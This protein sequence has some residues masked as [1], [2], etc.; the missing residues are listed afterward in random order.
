MRKV[1]FLIIVVFQILL[2]WNLIINDPILRRDDFDL[3]TPLKNINSLE[4]YFQLVET[5]KV[6][7]L[8]PIRDMTLLLNVKLEQYT[9]FGFYHLTNLIIWLA[10]LFA[11]WRLLERLVNTNAKYFWLILVSIHPS[12][13]TSVFWISGRKH[14]LSALFILI[15]TNLTLKNEN[16]YN[17]SIRNSSGI[18]GSYILSIFSQP[19]NLLWPLWFY[20]K[21][22]KS[23]I[24]IALLIVMFVCGYLNY[25]YYT[26]AFTDSV[27]DINKFNDVTILQSL[28]VSFLGLSRSFFQVFVPFKLAANYPVHSVFNLLGII[29]ILISIFFVLKK[30][31]WELMSW[32][33]FALLPL[34]VIYTK[35]TRIFVS[36]TYLI[37][38]AFGLIVIVAKSLEITLAKY[39]QKF[40]NA[41]AFFIILIFSVISFNW[42]QAWSSDEALWEYSYQSDPSPESAMIYCQILQSRGLFEEAFE[43]AVELRESNPERKEVPLLISQTISRN[44]KLSSNAKLELFKK[45]QTDDPWY[46][47]YYSTMLAQSGKWE[48]AFKQSSI[49]LLKPWVFEGDL[50]VVTAENHFFCVQA[51]VDNCNEKSEALI[52][53]FKGVPFSHEAYSLRLKALLNK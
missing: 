13:L 20:F 53:S 10:V 2:S 46:L 6:L 51:Q 12:L 8:Q 22:R 18:I 11:F 19:I 26:G 37:V 5:N 25:K 32:F 41:G 31:S 48:E 34:I 27:K 29:F 42:A 23:L 7:D 47:Y 1:V 45:Y 44:P 17:K 39:E 30:R 28:S 43:L 24:N 15:A 52:N 36:D 33:L 14:L 4:N 49:S 21:N 9:G 3:I 50:P 40:L 38:T 16:E 35:V